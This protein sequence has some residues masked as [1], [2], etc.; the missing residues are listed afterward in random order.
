MCLSQTKLPA[1][2]FHI[3][4]I[5]CLSVP[6]LAPHPPNLAKKH[7]DLR[8][9]VSVASHGIE[10]MLGDIREKGDGGNK[11]ETENILDFRLSRIASLTGICPGTSPC[12]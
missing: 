5:F 8:T 11:C 1:C 12:L 7:D 10:Q 3:F 2:F 4:V 6:A 9:H